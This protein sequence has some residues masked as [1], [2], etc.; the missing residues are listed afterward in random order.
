MDEA[1]VLVFGGWI[2][3]GLGKRADGMPQWEEAGE[4]QAKEGDVNK[5]G[6]WRNG[7]QTHAA[8]DSG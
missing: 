6:L 2:K 3:S 1:P 4:A 5:P 8:Q 7:P